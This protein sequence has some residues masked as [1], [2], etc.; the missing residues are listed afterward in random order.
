M[1][2]LLNINPTNLFIFFIIATV[3]F[4][5]SLMAYVTYDGVTS[6]TL[7]NNTTTKNEEAFKK[8]M[9]LIH[10]ALEEKEKRL[11]LIKV[12]VPKR[13]TF[14]KAILDILISSD[15]GISPYK[16]V[17]LLAVIVGSVTT[18]SMIFIP[19]AE[20]IILAITSTLIVILVLNVIRLHNVLQKEED[21]LQF[22]LVN[23]SNY[24]AAERIETA[25]IKTLESIDN[26]CFS[27]KALKNFLSRVEGANMS[28]MDALEKLKLDLGDFS[29]C[30]NMIDIVKQSEGTTSDFKPSI[31]GITESYKVK[32]AGQKESTN[33]YKVAVGMY[34]L[35][36][37]MMVLITIRNGLNDEL[38][39]LMP[40]SKIG[41]KAQ[42]AF[43]IIYLLIGLVVTVMTLRKKETEW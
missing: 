22:M 3:L 33:A 20:T 36:G 21:V 43:Y 27:A 14:I 41:P 16:A 31:F 1:D 28:K 17:V 5:L 2:I 35:E 37:I 11:K 29:Y 15:T 23:Q 19:I 8:R 39:R 4:M 38:A 18:I 32:L 34:A 12:K 9:L 30:N 6:N 26:D 40:L 13:D 7:Y 25:F 10:E 24:L 42:I